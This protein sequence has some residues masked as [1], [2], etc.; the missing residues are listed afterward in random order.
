LQICSLANVAAGASETP[1][2]PNVEKA[3]F[4]TVGFCPRKALDF[5]ADGNDDDDDE[6][7]EEDDEPPTDHSDSKSNDSTIPQPDVSAEPNSPDV[8]K[9]EV[10]AKNT[11][12]QPPPIPPRISSLPTSTPV[13]SS[14][15]SQ[16][17]AES[18]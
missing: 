9:P 11:K 13:A 8:P 4:L 5:D 15:L 17:I 6:E 10:V 12:L 16:K 14:P 18:K 2:N 1:V 3:D 7:E